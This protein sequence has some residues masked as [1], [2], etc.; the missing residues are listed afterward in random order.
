MLLRSSG[1]MKLMEN[2]WFDA[3]WKHHTHAM[4]GRTGRV[5]WS[6]L[7]ICLECGGMQELWKHTE[8]CSQHPK[9][10]L[11]DLCGLPTADHLGEPG[12]WDE[13]SPAW[14]CQAH[15]RFSDLYN[16]DRMKDEAAQAGMSV[17]DYWFNGR[18]Y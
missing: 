13:N 12:T 17:T 3:A 6:P 11:C 5:T 18:W 1:R 10:K 15:D 2:S 14:N 7:W 8:Q 9:N 16:Y 4:D